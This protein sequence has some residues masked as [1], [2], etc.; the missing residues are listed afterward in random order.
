MNIDNRSFGFRTLIGGL[1]LL[2][3]ISIVP[4][5]RYN[6]DALNFIVLA[7][8]FGLIN[9][10]LK[11]ILTA[12]TCPFV[13]LTL[14]FFLLVL[15]ALLLMLTASLGSTI[16]IPFFVHD[17]GAAFIGGIVI[18]LVGLLGVFLIPDRGRRYDHRGEI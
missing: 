6:G 18:S 8:I 13:L 1:G 2:I 3:A 14:G 12:L 9:A 10:L 7:L 17:F 5:L 16:G 11:P 4:G 15:N